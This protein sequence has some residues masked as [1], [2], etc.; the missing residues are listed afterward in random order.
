MSTVVRQGQSPLLALS[1]AAIAGLISMDAGSA[2]PDDLSPRPGESYGSRESRQERFLY[3]ATIAQS[4]TDPD[5]VA[6]IGADPR[7]RDFGTL[8]N[9]VDMPNVGD[10]LHHI[11]YSLHQ[12]RLIVPGLFSN[13]IHIF[14]IEGDGRRMTLR[15]V[16]EQLANDSGYIVPHSVIA[17]S[18]G[19]ALVT[20]LGAATPTS[21][22]GGIVEIDDF[23]GAFVRY[24]GPGPARVPGRPSPTYMYDFD[25]LAEA[26]R[27]IS[28]TFGPPASCAGGIDT[29]CL[30]HEVA[31]WDLGRREVVQVADLGVNSGALEVRFIEHEGVRRAFINTPGTSAVWLADDDDGDGVYD[32]Q[33][34]LGPEHGL[35]VPAD[36]LLSYD[37]RFM[38]LSNWFGN[39]VQQFDISDPYHPVL[40][41]TVPVPHPNMLRLSRDNRRLYVSN[42]LLTPWDDDTKLGPARNAE[43]GIWLFEVD[44]GTGA[45]VPVRAGGG[46]WVSFAAV[47]K[48]TSVG[49]AGPHMMLFDPSIRLEPGE[50]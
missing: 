14:D 24:F 13:R 45:M 31:V 16:N 12:N 7:H 47:P 4:A 44:A 10:E 18:H 46:A 37:H 27:G 25:S 49:A 20:M 1:I 39:T 21:Q 3:V 36:M 32:F 9:R 35:F 41:A 26:D 30:G 29:T 38:Y 15:A 22:P 23:T 11:G 48:K 2:R 19:R 50:H 33:P 42:S 40:T 34:V 6:V 5:F 43:Y 17:T 28:T 8:V